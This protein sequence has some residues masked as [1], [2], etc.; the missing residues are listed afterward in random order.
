MELF[1]RINN[2]GTAILM[3]THNHYLIEKF[4]GQILMCKDGALI[5]GE[6]EE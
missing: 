6:M 2:R 5:E 3:A 1:Q 4:P